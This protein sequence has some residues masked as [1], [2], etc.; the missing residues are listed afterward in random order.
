MHY[1]KSYL[2]EQMNNQIIVRY[3]PKTLNT[4]FFFFLEMAVH[5]AYIY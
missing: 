4:P 5:I 2:P 1:D 3:I